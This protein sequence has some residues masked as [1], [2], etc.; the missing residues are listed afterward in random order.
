MPPT[1]R[2]CAQVIFSIP[3]M[4]EVNVGGFSWDCGHIPNTIAMPVP[5]ANGC[6][7]DS[8]QEED[9]HTPKNSTYPEYLCQGNLQGLRSSWAARDCLISEF[10]L[11][12]TDYQGERTLLEN[13]QLHDYLMQAGSVQLAP[14]MAIH[15][16]CNVP[17]H[18]IPL[19]SCKNISA[20]D[21][22]ELWNV[23]GV[24]VVTCFE[25]LHQLTRR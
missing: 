24:I 20:S 16:Y 1:S 6:C 19:F 21:Y 25:F 2:S 15:I 14:W 17:L 3:P 8:Q 11:Y 5:A 7:L 9:Q 12:L 13:L 4:Q 22:F 10:L 18:F 23:K